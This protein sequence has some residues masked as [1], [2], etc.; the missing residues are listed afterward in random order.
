MMTTTGAAGPERLFRETRPGDT[1]Q[2]IWKGKRGDYMTL[3]LAR[4]APDSNKPW[5]Y[6]AA[7]H[8]ETGEVV[9]F[10]DTQMVAMTQMKAVPL[11][12]T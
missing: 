8:L 2:A 12:N 11:T 10:A 4:A 1:F 9:W 7:A 6:R 5:D 3:D